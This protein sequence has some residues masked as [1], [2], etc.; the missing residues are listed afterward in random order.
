MVPQPTTWLFDTHILIS[1]IPPY[2]RYWTGLPNF[3]DKYRIQLKRLPYMLRVTLF[4][5]LPNGRRVRI[6]LI[7]KSNKQNED[8]Y[9]RDTI[10]AYASKGTSIFERRKYPISEQFE[11]YFNRST[12]PAMVNSLL[13]R[14]SV[15]L[16]PGC[17]QNWF[18]I[19]D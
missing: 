7:L 11:I 12:K 6:Y 19:R 3:W 13:P 16:T 15:A 5:F 18:L 4:R 17:L 14:Y 9:K 8:T 10:N 1:G 2:F